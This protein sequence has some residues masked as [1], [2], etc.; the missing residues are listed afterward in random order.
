MSGAQLRSLIPII[1]VASLAYRN[2]CSSL[3]SYVF[4]FMRL[5]ERCPTFCP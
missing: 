1:V 5:K 4:L 2:T 3:S